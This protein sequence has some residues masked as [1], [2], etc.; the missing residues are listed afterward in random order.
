MKDVNV[1]GESGQDQG[2]S[3]SCKKSTKKIREKERGKELIF[4][5]NIVKIGEFGCLVKNVKKNAGK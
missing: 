4:R 1:Q 5:A 2:I 3:M